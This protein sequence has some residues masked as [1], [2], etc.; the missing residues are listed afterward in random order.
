MD[1]AKNKQNA[2]LSLMG[3]KVV[4]GSGIGQLMDDLGRAM[5]GTDDV[6]MLGGGNPAAIPE[7]KAIWRKRMQE[8]LADP[9]RFDNI[10]G[11]YDTPKGSE[12]FIA[13]MANLLNRQ[14]NWD[15]TPANI[16]VMNGSQTASYG[17]V[18]LLGGAVAGKTGKRHIL[19]P[20]SPEYIGYADQS[21]TSG[22]IKANRAEIEKIGTH[23]FRYRIA[24]DR[25][26]LNDSVG[27]VLVSRPTNPT[28]N[29]I[30]D[31]DMRRLAALCAEKDIPLIIDNAYGQPFPGAVFVDAALP[32]THTTT[33]LFSLSK[34]GLPGTRTGCVVGPPWIVNALSAMNGVLSLANGNV[35][36][37]LALP[38]IESGDVIQLGQEKILPFYREKSRN[39]QAYLARCFPDAVPYRVHI[40][41]GAFFLW[42]W[43]EDLPVTSLELYQRL[44]KRG[45]LVVAGEHFF[46][47]LQG[48]WQHAHECIR[49]T[50]SQDDEIVK[51]GIAL[52]ADEVKTLYGY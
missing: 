38:L 43:F 23:Q 36:Q 34:L 41:E 1:M 48:P 22:H 44:R 19:L 13:A 4:N 16:A 5:A 3:E 45:V 28:G 2:R 31:A 42:L 20:T 6:L 35:G 25:L 29:V 11:N 52:I 10:L 18:N 33:H 24:F 26:Q 12:P 21:T 49:I 30:N 8:L 47:G 17:L 14:Y 51:S 46:F 27:A 40:S 7:V 39:A 9:A 37:A 50:F 15:V 32:W